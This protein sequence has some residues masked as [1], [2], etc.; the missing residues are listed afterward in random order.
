M[1]LGNLIGRYCRLAF[2]GSWLWDGKEY[3]GTWLGSALKNKHL[4]GKRKKSDWAEG[5]V[6]LQCSNKKWF[7]CNWVVHSELYWAGVKESELYISTWSSGCRLPPGRGGAWEISSAG[8]N[9]WTA[10]AADDHQLAALLD[11]RSFSLEE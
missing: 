7:N 3:S 1:W 5:K 11:A 4:W 10:L 2:S 8:S 9:P 6:R